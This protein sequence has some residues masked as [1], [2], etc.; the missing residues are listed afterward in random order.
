MSAH[1]ATVNDGPSDR[2]LRGVP[3]FR[4]LGGLRTVGG[5]TIR[6]GVL[7]RSSGLEELTASDVTCLVD[8]IGLRTVIDLRSHHDHEIAEPLLGTGI[9]VVNI[10]IER[11]GAPT[12]L[13]RP[14]RP[15]GRADMSLVYT[16]LL[17][18]SADRFAEIIKLLVNGATPAVFHCVS[19]KDRTGVVAALVL[20]SVGVTREGVVA[21][22]MRTNTVL[23]ELVAQL[24]RRPAYAGIVDQLPP[25]V[26]DVEPWYIAD[27]LAGIDADHGGVRQWL[28]NRAGV[29]M[30]TLDALTTL[31]VDTGRP[32]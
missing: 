27:F 5:Q 4:D 25:G 12:D 2:L 8:K 16:M 10:P 17:H 30:A 26:L 15:D 13:T 1:I 21:D 9:E 22:F 20:E 3:N 6:S 28:M 24:H 7:F 19:G 32:T 29:T 23:G 14:M 31:L 11:D 18:K